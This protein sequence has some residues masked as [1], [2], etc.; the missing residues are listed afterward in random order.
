M[1]PT[2]WPDGAITTTQYLRWFSNL[3]GALGT[4][5]DLPAVLSVGTHTIT[6]EAE[7]SAGLTATTE[8]TL[9]VSGDYDGDTIADT[10]EAAD[11]LNPLTSND[12]FSDA[13]GDNLPL[14]MELHYGTDPNSND[15]DGDG[16][17]DD[18]EIVEQTDPTTNDTPPLPD[19][20]Q[21]SPQ[22]LT[23]TVD[24]AEDTVLPQDFVQIF[25]RDTRPF[26]AT[27]DVGWLSFSAITGTTPAQLTVVINPI[28]LVDGT[29]VGSI[30]VNS[31]L[32]TITVP[33]TVTA[34]NKGEF[35]DANRDG[36]TNQQDI[37]A[38]Q[39]RVG[40]VWGDANYA[41]QYDVDRDGDIDAQDVGL[42]STC[43]AT[44]GD[45]RALY[46]PLIRK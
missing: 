42:I 9:T 5:A 11:G 40:A 8:I 1:L 19:V 27:A 38:V 13:D 31:E 21:V 32:G 24:L 10:V 37:Q 44:Y 36:A 6:L 23:M 14:V 29:Q 2:S 15:S 39:S 34:S 4:G 46:L 30:T 7:N 28:G 12:A 45:V 3:D 41:V 18:E 20:L 17:T 16:R 43:A 25:S 33:V 22:A 35:C 26:T